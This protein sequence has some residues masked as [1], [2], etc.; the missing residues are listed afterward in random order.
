MKDTEK[1]RAQFLQLKISDTNKVISKLYAFK[2]TNEVVF[3]NL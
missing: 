2:W 1:R 3:K